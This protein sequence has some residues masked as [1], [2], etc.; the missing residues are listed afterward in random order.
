MK[1][2]VNASM[3]EG[4]ADY[5]VVV[6]FGGYFGASEEITVFAKAG[7]DEETLLQV[8]CDDYKDE[9]LE[10]EIVDFDGE[11][12]YTVEVNFAGYIG[13]SEEYEVYADSEEEALD[14]AIQDACWSLD[15]ESF[16]VAE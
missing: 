10:A 3:F 15:I 12:G 4:Y 9:L 5:D 8:I 11:D 13:V 14:N 6:T 1:R 2:Y 7:A 16:K